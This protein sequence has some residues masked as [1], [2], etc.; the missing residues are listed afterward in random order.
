MA[1]HQHLLRAGG[2]QVGHR[3]QRHALAVDDRQADQVDPVVL[4]LFRRGKDERAM[5][6]RAPFRPSAA[7]WSGM[8]CALATTVSRGPGLA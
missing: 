4:A 5:K 2:H 7:V 8:S 6:M 1:D 3:A